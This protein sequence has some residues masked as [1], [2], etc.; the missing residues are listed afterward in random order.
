MP[1]LWLIAI[2]FSIP[3]FYKGGF[4]PFSSFP[5]QI[6]KKVAF[7]PLTVCW[8]WPRCGPGAAHFAHNGQ[9]PLALR[10]GPPPV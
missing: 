3:E 10:W 4:L 2:Q 1:F 6:S 8:F 9:S 5:I 7:Y